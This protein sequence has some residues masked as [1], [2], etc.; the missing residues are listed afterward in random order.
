MA[1]FPD[2]RLETGAGELGLQDVRALDVEDHRVTLAEAMDQIAPEEDQQLVSKNDS[3][4]FV[5]RAD[6][7]A[8]PIETDSQLGPGPANRLL[9]ILEVFHHGRIGMVIGK[10]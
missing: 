4:L 3:S 7:I 5:H 10:A 1:R 2:H 6:A 8:I 9:Q